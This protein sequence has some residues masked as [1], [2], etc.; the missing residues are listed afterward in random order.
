VATLDESTFVNA[1]DQRLG[2]VVPF[3]VSDAEGDDVQLV[4]QW[5]LAGAA[6]PTLPTTAAALTAALADPAQRKTLQI[7]SSY[8][9]A[10]GGRLMAA[11]ATTVELP[12][13][14]TSMGTWLGGSAAADVDDAL[15]GLELQL[16]RPGLQL[17]QLAADWSTNPL[18]NP[19]AALPEGAGSTALVLDQ[20]AGGLSRLRRIDL[21]SGAVLA[22]LA[23]GL[24][25]P[26][27]LAL[28][29]GGSAVLIGEHDG[30]SWRVQRVD[31]STLT[32]TQLFNVS[33]PGSSGLRG[34]VSL[35]SGVALATVDDTLLKLDYLKTPAA[36]TPVLDGL[37]TPGG[38]V[39]DP[40]Q[41][42]TVLVAE[43][44]AGGGRILSVSLTSRSAEVLGGS[45]S[46]LPSPTAL[47]LEDGGARL[48]VLTDATPGDGTRE[49]RALQR[50]GTVTPAITL[51]ADD[52]PDSALGLA[53]GRS[54]LRL[55]ALGGAHDLA[56]AGGVQ[57]RR[58]VTGYDP[59]TRLVTVTDAFSPALLS[60]QPW[61]LTLPASLSLMPGVTRNGV[62][63][64]DSRDLPGSQGTAQ[65]RLTA[66][67]ATSTVTS[68]DT[69]KVISG[70]LSRLATVIGGTGVT[71]GL[72]A[73]AVADLNNDGSLDVVSANTV[74]DRLSV[75]FSD[76]SGM[77]AAP[78]LSLG[79][80]AVSDMP[81]GV[82]AADL[83]ADGDVDLISANAGTDN[84]TIFF[85]TTPGVFGLLPTA[86]GGPGPTTAPVAV[87]TADF[88][89][90]GSVDI[91]SA[92]SGGDDLALFFQ[93]SPSGLL[94]LKLGG[95]GVTDAPRAL[96]TG[97]MDSD[98]DTDLVSANTTGDS[99]TIFA[100]TG[101]GFFGATPTTLASASSLDAPLALVA[102]DLDGDGDLDLASA[103]ALSNNVTVFHQTGSGVF[104]PLPDV[105]G[106]VTT[107]F[108]SR[109][110]AARDIDGDG[111]IELVTANTAADTLSVFF[112]TT[113]G[114][115]SPN[116]AT[117][118][119]MGT[120]DGP[121]SVAVADLDGDGDG[122]VLSA[123]VVGNDLTVFAYDGPGRIDQ[124]PLTLGSSATTNAPYAIAMAD[125]DGDGDNDLASANQAANTLSIFRQSAPGKFDATPLTVGGGGTT[126][127]PRAVVAADF[128]GDGDFDLASANSLNDNLTLFL[129]QGDG[130]FPAAPITLGGDMITDFPTDLDTADFDGDGDLDVVCSN[131][132]GDSLT[133]FT[134]DP[135]GFDPV[136]LV[137]D[138]MGVMDFAFDLALG[139]L[140]DD[141]DI[142]IVSANAASDNLTVFFHTTGELFNLTPAVLGS[143]AL[144]DNPR[145]VCVADVDQDGDLDIVS[146]NAGSHSVTS[147]R[148]LSP[149]VFSGFPN[150]IAD[151]S[152][153]T[154][155]RSVVAVDLDGDGDLDLASA[156]VGDD[157]FTVF[158]QISPGRFTAA[159]TII[160]GVGITDD[161]FALAGLDVD[162]DGDNDLVSANNAG[163]SL[164]IF[165]SGHEP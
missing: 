138:G 149:G 24:A 152:S 31:L 86:L 145:S 118:G 125:F 160:G 108:D 75:F 39:L 41:P 14:G 162:G 150:T 70:G 140:D 76:G 8:P 58:V 44:D 157:A 107:T 131:G 12:E 119:G 17:Q 154:T 93:P 144:T 18:D 62:F 126:S 84:L 51:L 65:L 15:F 13:L 122:D 1:G 40:T 48:L 59:A 64:W 10:S 30:S 16:L 156:N 78:Q 109:G 139:D 99:L 129:Q 72:Q 67:D 151:A 137:L 112:Q 9:V 116:P 88:N 5:T 103:N 83:D 63:V 22:D 147:F 57:Q 155:P 128:N 85:Q 7:A 161:P 113:P 111:S 165:F 81:S 82:A 110:L 66:M 50:F 94:F 159:P 68:H 45:A 97:D 32:T 2:L 35:G 115:F 53:T 95:S 6:F 133:V 117:L 132:G 19:V 100:H 124:V 69:G 80:S 123:N 146:A 87:A 52:L 34:L 73:F 26:D 29:A 55:L 91:A 104:S 54:N 142:D 130:S 43:Q 38:L 77:F 37:A 134:R 56:A 136:P 3:T 101:G 28:E 60:G 4:F 148:Q 143:T 158:R 25:G 33:A 153:V 89:E 106:G 120:T 96:A 49:L 74:G 42:Q 164:T 114:S 105:L 98:G 47:A 11:G 36:S 20:T 92:N 135:L 141:G 61:R 23:L 21:G 127:G 121:R 90:D 71:N 27:A 163:D 102:A 79:S 46:G